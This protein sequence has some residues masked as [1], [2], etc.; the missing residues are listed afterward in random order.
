V[1]NCKSRRRA[2]GLVNDAETLAHLDQTLHR[3][4]IGVGVQFASTSESSANHS[5]HQSRM[6]A[7]LSA[8]PPAAAKS[9]ESH[10]RCRPR[11]Q[12][13]VHC[14][15]DFLDPDKSFFWLRGRLPSC[16][17]ARRVATA[18]AALEAVPGPS[19]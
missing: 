13:R 3:R 11:G 12:R 9:L 17:S 1:G 6:K 14:E 15:P 8:L 4:G 19:I 2:Q 7:R 16:L 10:R 18:G 5:P